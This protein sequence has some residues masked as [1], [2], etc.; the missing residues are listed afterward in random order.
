MANK[1]KAHWELNCTELDYVES[2]DPETKQDQ[3]LCSLNRQLKEL[4]QIHAKTGA[5]I[6]QLQHVQNWMQGVD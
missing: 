1:I 4:E 5:L 6:A 2:N 3:I